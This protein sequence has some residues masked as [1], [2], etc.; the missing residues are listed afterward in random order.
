[1]VDAVSRKKSFS[2]KLQHLFH[3]LHISLVLGVGFV[4]ELCMAPCWGVTDILKEDNG[5]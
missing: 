1:M 2:R 5:L 4:G 3:W